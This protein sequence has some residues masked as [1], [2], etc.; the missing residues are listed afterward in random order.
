MSLL[1]I[2]AFSILNDPQTERNAARISNTRNQLCIR[3]SLPSKQR[4][5]IEFGRF[6]FRR[7]MRIKYALEGVGVTV[8]LNMALL[9]NW[10][11]KYTSFFNYQKFTFVRC[12]VYITH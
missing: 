5:V 2:D 11:P 9:F 6:L 10:S 3:I 4:F 7:Q 1:I 12:K 8:Y